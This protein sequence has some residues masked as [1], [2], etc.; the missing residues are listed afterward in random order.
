[1]S[2]PGL[3]QCA[4]HPCL[5]KNQLAMNGRRRNSHRFSRFVIGEPTEE[6]K[7]NDLALAGITLGETLQGLIQVKY[8]SG[9]V[10]PDHDSMVQCDLFESTTTLV[11]VARLRMI[12]QDVT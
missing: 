11:T 9:D 8:V 5:R 4:M 12:Y 10:S 3:A 1:M 2:G 6:E 7:F